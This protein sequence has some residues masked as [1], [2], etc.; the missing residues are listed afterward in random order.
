MRRSF[1]VKRSVSR[2]RPWLASHL[3][4]RLLLDNPITSIAMSSWRGTAG[5]KRPLN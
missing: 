5:I 3:A 4:A 1:V 2:R